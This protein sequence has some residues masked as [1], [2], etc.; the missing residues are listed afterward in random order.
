VVDP[1]KRRLLLLGWARQSKVD[2]REDHADAG[3][4]RNEII[5]DEN[6]IETCVTRYI[7]E[8]KKYKRWHEFGKDELVNVDKIAAL[9]MLVVLAVRPFG[10]ETN[11]VSTHWAAHANEF[12]ALRCF[13]AILGIVPSKMKHDRV[14]KE[15]LCS[16]QQFGSLKRIRPELV[17]PFVILAR[18]KREQY[19]GTGTL[20]D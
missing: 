17:G 3:G 10:S 16:F 14:L 12:Y 4:R 1:I 15:L 13:I 6:R 5:L 7:Q 18:T 11:K 20:Q 8:L 9:T 2:F 19:D